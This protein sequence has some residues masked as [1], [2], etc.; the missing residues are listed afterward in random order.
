MPYEDIKRKYHAFFFSLQFEYIFI[1][2]GAM[3]LKKFRVNGI[4]MN[5]VFFTI[6]LHDYLRA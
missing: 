3:I 2:S 4:L 5:Y 6:S 1:P